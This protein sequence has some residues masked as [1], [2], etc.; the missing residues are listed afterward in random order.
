MSRNGAGFEYHEQKHIAYSQR[1]PFVSQSFSQ[2]RTISGDDLVESGRVEVTSF[3]NYKTVG[4]KR[5]DPIESPYGPTEFPLFGPQYGMTASKGVEPIDLPYGKAEV[6]LFGP[7][8]GIAALSREEDLY[9]GSDEERRNNRKIKNL[10]M[11]KVDD[12]NPLKDV[13]QYID[14]RSC[15]QGG[16]APGGLECKR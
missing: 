14:P 6:P 12:L 2:T 13:S 5:F 7:Q 11:T 15:I 16:K 4:S 8:Y 9:N 3:W 10:T 1:S